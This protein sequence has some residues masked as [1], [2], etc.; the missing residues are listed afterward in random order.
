MMYYVNPYS[1]S[2]GDGNI[3]E[4][5]EPLDPPPEVLPPEPLLSIP[6]YIEPVFVSD[7]MNLAIPV[8]SGSN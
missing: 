1:D 5:P 8:A 4:D 2:Y 7:N 3:I 6:V